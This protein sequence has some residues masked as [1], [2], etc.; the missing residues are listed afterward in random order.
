M[1]LKL[2]PRLLSSSNEEDYIP[3]GISHV[4][5]FGLPLSSYISQD[6]SQRT[7]TVGATCSDQ[8]VIQYVDAST[9]LICR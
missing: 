3:P 8:L 6:V 1:P 9:L 7:I 5:D 2:F 4:F